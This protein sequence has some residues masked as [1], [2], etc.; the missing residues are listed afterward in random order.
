MYTNVFPTVTTAVF[1][2]SGADESSVSLI[3]LCSICTSS[4]LAMYHN[5]PI[6]DV[7]IWV[8]FDAATSTILI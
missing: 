3:S 6:P 1:E 2:Q 5:I 4:K 7:E 8:T